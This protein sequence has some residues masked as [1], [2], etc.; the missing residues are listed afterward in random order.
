[1]FR[2]MVFWVIAGVLVW[3]TSGNVHAQQAPKGAPAAKA[4]A[5]DVQVRAEWHRT[6]AALLAEQAKPQPDEEKI[7]S[8]RSQLAELR[9]QM[10]AGVQVQGFC[11]YGGPVQARSRVGAGGAGAGYGAGLAGRGGS[12]AGR[13][14]YGFSPGA[15]MGQGRGFGRGAAAGIGGRGRGP[16]GMR[17]GYGRGR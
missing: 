15:G 10:N 17:G 7:A 14:P 1:M 3:T 4:A 9:T 8:L 16:G 13:C 12:A 6:I 11:P 2:K 5:Q